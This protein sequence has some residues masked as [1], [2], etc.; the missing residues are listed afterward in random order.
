[1]KGMQ[2]IRAMFFGFPQGVSCPGCGNDTGIASIAMGDGAAIFWCE[3]DCIFDDTGAIVPPVP[4][5]RAP[6][7][8]RVSR[9]RTRMKES[10]SND[11]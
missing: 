11:V 6:D 9:T 5:G 8:D 1:M 10:K 2:K 4:P 3:C 7:Q